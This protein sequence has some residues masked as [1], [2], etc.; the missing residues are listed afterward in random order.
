MQL[1]VGDRFTDATGECEV[2]SHPHTTV[3][4]K[5]LLRDAAQC[6]A[7]ADPRGCAAGHSR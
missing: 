2:I 5:S 3:G 1:K 4:A 6:S 7:H